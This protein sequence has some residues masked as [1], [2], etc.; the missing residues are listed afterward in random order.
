MIDKHDTI[1]LFGNDSLRASCFIDYVWKLLE[2]KIIYVIGITDSSTISIYIDNDSAII[3]ATSDYNILCTE[4]FN[5][6]YNHVLTLM[7]ELCIS[8]T[9]RFISSDLKKTNYDM[10]SFYYEE[11]NREDDGIV[12]IYCDAYYNIESYY[13]FKEELTSQLAKELQYFIHRNVIVSDIDTCE[14]A[15]IDSVF[16]TV[17]MQSKVKSIDFE[18][19]AKLLLDNDRICIEDYNKICKIKQEVD[20]EIKQR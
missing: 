8:L 3:S 2:N 17:N 7:S 14:I 12:E 18:T 11:N 16:E 20:N 9:I 4:R 15:R 19:S 1:S 10:C 13:D 6:Y 5:F